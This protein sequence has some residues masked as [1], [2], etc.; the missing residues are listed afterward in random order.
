MHHFDANFSKFSG[1]DPQPPPAGGGDPLSNPPPFGATRLSEAFGFIG[2]LC[3]RQWRFWIRPWGGEGTEG[4]DTPPPWDLSEVGSCVE[5]WWVGEEVQRLF[6]LTVIFFFASLANLLRSMFIMEQSSFLYISCFQTMKRIQISILCFY[7]RAF[8]YFSCL[9]LHDF[10]LHHLRQKFSG[11]TPTAPLPLLP[12]NIYNQNYHVICVCVERGLQKDHALPIRNL[13]VN[14]N[15]CLESRYKK[16][17][18][19]DL[20]GKEPLQTSVFFLFLS[21]SSLFIFFCVFFFACQIFRES[22]NPPPPPPWRKFLDP[23]LQY[24]SS[25]KRKRPN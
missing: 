15:N 21:S 12:R 18:S 19:A 20:E 16:N 14:V 8:S 4:P 3:P 23:R 25:V 10:T 17:T 9:Q 11:W 1:G 7:E 5:A 2:H 6:Y 13:Y 22:W 24:W